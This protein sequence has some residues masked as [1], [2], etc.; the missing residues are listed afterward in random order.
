MANFFSKLILEMHAGSQDKEKVYFIA[1][2]GIRECK[3]HITSNCQ[4]T[5]VEGLGHCWN[6]NFANTL[7]V[8]VLLPL[9]LTLLSG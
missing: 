5:M 4:S 9:A 8:M 3:G 1:D 6:E 7:W 2:A